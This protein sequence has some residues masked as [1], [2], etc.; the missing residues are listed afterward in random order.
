MWT[1]DASGVHIDKAKFIVCLVTSR[2]PGGNCKVILNADCGQGE[3]DQKLAKSC[4][5]LL[6]MAP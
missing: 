6:W 4:G 1:P 5:R 3:G 2:R